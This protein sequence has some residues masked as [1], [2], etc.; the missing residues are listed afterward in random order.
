MIA[1]DKKMAIA[2]G[3]RFFFG[4]PCA[5]ADHHPTVRYTKSGNCRLCFAERNARAY[6]AKKQSEK[7]ELKALLGW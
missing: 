7:A 1:A 3:H 2:E 4:S 5:D 6:A